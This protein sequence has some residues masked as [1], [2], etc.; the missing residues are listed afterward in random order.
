MAENKAL[1]AHEQVHLDQVR[2]MGWI[3]FYWNYIT[4]AAFRHSIETLG[5]LKQ[6]EV[7]RNG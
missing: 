4:N 3:P 7:E 6:R 1:L 5:Y 2:A